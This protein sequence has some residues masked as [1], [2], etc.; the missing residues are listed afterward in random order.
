M[1]VMR[2]FIA[3]QQRVNVAT[4]EAITESEAARQQYVITQVAYVITQVATMA[5]IRRLERRLTSLNSGGPVSSHQTSSGESV[6][7]TSISIGESE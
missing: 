4:L 5:E 1:R 7:D 2:P 6:A 3:Y